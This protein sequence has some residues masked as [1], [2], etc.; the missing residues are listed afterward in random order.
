M[1]NLN[2]FNLIINDATKDLKDIADK[3]KAADIDCIILFV[4]PPASLKLIEQLRLNNINLPVYGT[5]AQLDENK[6]PDTGS[7]NV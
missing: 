2:Q 6:I 1:A 3:L 7:E 4:Q 5:L